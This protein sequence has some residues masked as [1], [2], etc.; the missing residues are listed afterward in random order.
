MLVRA[1]TIVPYLGSSRSSCAPVLAHCPTLGCRPTARLRPI[2]RA[3]RPDSRHVIPRETRRQGRTVP[4]NSWSAQAPAASPSPTASGAMP[5]AGDA[6]RARHAGSNAYTYTHRLA[7]F[8][9]RVRAVPA[10]APAG[11]TH[12]NPVRRA[13]ARPRVCGLVHERLQQPGPIAVE[14][15]AV[16]ADRPRRPPNPHE[17]RAPHPRPHETRAV[18]VRGDVG[19]PGGCGSCHPQGGG[20][21]T[22]VAAFFGGGNHPVPVSKLTLRVRHRAP[23]RTRPGGPWTSSES[24]PAAEAG[25]SC[26]G[27]A[28][29]LPPPRRIPDEQRHG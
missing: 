9:R 8:G 15:L 24:N 27:R 7:R 10:P 3:R 17:G 23:N 12:P 18:S 22:V 2:V 21:G 20:S 29:P 5:G 16:G 28:L 4:P 13:H 26:T 11:L 14:A 6:R 25:V 19:P 1:W